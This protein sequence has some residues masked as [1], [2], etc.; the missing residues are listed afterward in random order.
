MRPE[1][2]FAAILAT[3]SSFGGTTAHIEAFPAPK[4]AVTASPAL[5]RGVEG[6]MTVTTERHGDNH[7]KERLPRIE[8][9][10]IT[11]RPARILT[12]GKTAH[13]KSVWIMVDETEV[14]A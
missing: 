14:D 9:K 1:L 2:F 8:Q 13:G 11:E 7:P 10:M 3:T 6:E 4:M 5:M 12:A